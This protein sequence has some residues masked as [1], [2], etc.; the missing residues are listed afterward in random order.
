MARV[1]KNSAS[2]NRTPGLS[3]ETTSTTYGSTS[4]C[5]AL[6]PVRETET[7]RPSSRSR[8]AA[9]DSSFAIASQE[10]TASNAITTSWP[11]VERR[12]SSTLQ[13]QSLTRLVRGRSDAEDCVAVAVTRT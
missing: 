8:R 11:S 4:L 2:W 9:D 7:L 12:A 3:A 13:P 1:E 6:G 10:P 5:C